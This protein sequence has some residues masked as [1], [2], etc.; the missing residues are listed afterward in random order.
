MSPVDE[1]KRFTS[2]GGASMGLDGASA[3]SKYLSAPLVSL[4]S[5]KQMYH[6]K[7]QIQVI[8]LKYTL[9]SYYYAL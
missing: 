7:I 4:I 6:L 8:F 5:L 2:S 9:I 3:P 1:N